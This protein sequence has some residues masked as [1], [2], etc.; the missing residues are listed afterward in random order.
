MK[1]DDLVAVEPSLAVPR[2]RPPA[3]LWI[4]LGITG[5][6]YVGSALIYMLLIGR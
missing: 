3:S 6:A 4:L 1:E 5:L 2:G